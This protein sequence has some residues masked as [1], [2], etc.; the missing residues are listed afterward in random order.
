MPATTTDR[1]TVHFQMRTARFS[2]LAGLDS[3]SGL[4]GAFVVAVFVAP[5]AAWALLN[6]AP[7]ALPWM[8]TW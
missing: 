8:T 1:S 7:S 3:A 5:R 2:F 4:A 6:T